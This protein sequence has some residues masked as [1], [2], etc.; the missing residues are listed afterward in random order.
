MFLCQKFTDWQS[1]SIG[2]DLDGLRVCVPVF[3]VVSYPL[4]RKQSDDEAP[5]GQDIRAGNRQF[6]DSTRGD[7]IVKFAKEG[8]VMLH[9]TGNW[10]YV[11]T[12]S[13][14][15][16]SMEEL[17]AFFETWNAWLDEGRPFIAI[18]RFLDEEALLQPRGAAREVKLWF[19]QNTDRIRALVLGMA[20]IVPETVYEQVSRMDAEKLFRVPCGHLFPCRSCAPLA[21]RPGGAAPWPRF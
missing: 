10:P 15:A 7:E 8:S 12:L 1:V 18:R 21:Q 5:G 20:H 17:R 2:D 3:R 13:K 9:D 19:Q 11:V 14:G 4:L 6:L 16:L